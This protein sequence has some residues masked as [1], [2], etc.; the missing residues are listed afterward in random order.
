MNAK[1]ASVAAPRMLSTEVV[2]ACALRLAAQDGFEAVS[3]GK[4]ARSLGC[5]VT[6][7]YT[8]VDS[9]DDLRV[10]MAVEVQRELADRLWEAALARAGVDALRAIAQ[11]YRSFG[12]GQPVH[13]RVLFTMTSTTDERFR[14]GGQ[15]LAE[16]VRATLRS[17][18]LDEE[19]VRHAHRAFGAAM[20]GFLLAEAQ[21]QYGSD[22]DQTFEQLIALFTRG[23]ASG[24]WPVIPASTSNESDMQGS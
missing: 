4:I 1:V 24:D 14:A 2:V 15:R 21:G 12:A 16:P 8:H 19:A 6:S 5:H 3:L 11:V 20:R 17:L 22:A 9:I 7:L 13:V 18:G 10:R 23:L